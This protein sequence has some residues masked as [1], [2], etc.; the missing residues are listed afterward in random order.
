MF[1]LFQSME[2]GLNG[3]NGA[4]AQKRVGGGTRL[5]PVFVTI[6][7]QITEVQNVTRTDL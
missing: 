6:L 2:N 1:S 5:D 3:V 4:V 7:P